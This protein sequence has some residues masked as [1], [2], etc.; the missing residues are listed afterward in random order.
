MN[1]RHS[2]TL[3]A[4]LLIILAS[5]FVLLPLFKPGFIVTDDGDWM[6]IRLTAF[7]QAFSDGQFPVRFLGRLN[8]NY[9]YPVSNFLYPGFLYL[10]A[11]MRMAKIPYTFIVELLIGGS[12]A[13]AAVFLYFWLRKFFTNAA[14]LFGA[15]SFLVSPY[16]LYDLYKRG[17][18]GE[19]VGTASMAVLMY[20]IEANVVW[21]ISP[22]FAF[23]LLSHNTLS[24]LYCLFLIG[25]VIVR[26]RWNTIVPLLIG[27]TMTLFFWMP[28]LFERSFVRFDTIQVS[29]PVD[30]LGISQTLLLMSFPFFVPILWVVRKQVG[31]WK[32]ESVYLGVVALIAA[33]GSSA[34]GSVLWNMREFVYFV[35]FPYRLLSL[36]F[37][38]GPWL[39]AFFLE[40]LPRR[41][42]V[43]AGSLALVFL[44][45][46]STPLL[47]TARSVVREEGYYTTNEGTTT[48]QDEYMPI[49]VKSVPGERANEKVTLFSGKGTIQPVRSSTK[50]TDVDVVF[51]EPGVL[52]F[53]TVFYP[54]WGGLID[55]KPVEIIYTNDKGV[56]RIK[57]PKGPHR[58]TFEFRETVFRYVSDI[59]TSVGVGLYGLYVLYCLTQGVR[60]RSRP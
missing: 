5:V 36:L 39:L 14:S 50:R 16:V 43:V 23:L 13:G 3:T 35:Q 25:Y 24:L 34:L 22:V 59:A 12:V 41:I 32:R 27:A 1:K 60:K 51:E 2:V 33:V 45:S 57:V 10:G 19:L 38:A 11:F 42:R 54:G 6:V 56:M 46:G 26:R 49:W 29:N 9:G 28:A 4:V 48:V 20:L 30:Y 17:S 37:L 7:Y 21:L 47:Y 31:K 58:V 8:H 18:V 53:N 52:E 55:G 44:V 40:H 15:V